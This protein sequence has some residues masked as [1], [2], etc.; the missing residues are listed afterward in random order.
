MKVK[1]VFGF[2]S[3]VVFSFSCLVQ[4]SRT[5]EE[6]DFG[7]LPYKNLSEYGF[8]AGKIQ[9][10]NPQNTVLEYEPISPLFTDYAFKSRFVW[11]PKGS[12]AKLSADPNEAFLFPDKSILIKNFYYPEDFNKPEEN[13]RILETRLLVKNEGKWEAYPYVWKEDQTDAV[14]KVTGG[15]KEISWKDKSGRDQLLTYA[16]P[17]KNQ[18][19]S[20]H[21]KNDVFQPIGP[22]VK[23]LNNQLSYMDGTRENQLDK[24]VKMGYLNLNQA[25]EGFGLLVNPNDETASLDLRARSYLDANCAHCHEKSGPASTSGLYLNLEEENPFHWG[26]L[27]SPVAAGIGAG[28][29]KYAILPG[30]GDESIIVHRMNSTNPGVMMPEIG[31]V[32][33][34]KEGVEVVRKWINEMPVEIN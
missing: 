1:R 18:C 25:M 12:S 2:V 24:W 16:M 34:H 9:E 14:Y 17:N 22:K 3:L 5:P 15:S 7:I 29:F 28:S 23:Q 21:N 26:I 4:P 30:K 20:C 19:K 8:F 31:R 11:M 32:S 10:L 27:K 33:I 13:R 6:I